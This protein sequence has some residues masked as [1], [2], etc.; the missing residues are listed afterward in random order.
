MPTFLIQLLIGSTVILASVV[1]FSTL[2]LRASA[3][4][5][6]TCFCSVMIALLVLPLLIPFLPVISPIVK[7]MEEPP[8]PMQAPVKIVPVKTVSAE[9]IMLTQ[10]VDAPQWS[11]QPL[12]PDSAT[13]TFVAT[14]EPIIAEPA[15]FVATDIAEPVQNMETVTTPIPWSLLVIVTLLCGMTIRLVML[16]ASIMTTRNLV[17][18]SVPFE[19]PQGLTLAELCRKFRLRRDLEK[20]LTSGQVQVPFAAGTFRPVVFLPVSLRREDTGRLRLVLM[21][22]LAHIARH[23]VFWQLLTRVMLAVYWFHPLAWLLARYIRREREFACDDAVLLLREYPEDYASVLLDISKSLRRK[24]VRLSGCTVAMAQT[25]Q[26]ENRICA[27]LDPERIRKPLGRL[28]AV[29]LVL[30]ACTL[31]ALAGMFS[32]IAREVVSNDEDEV[33]V[34]VEPEEVVQV[35]TP[36]AIKY[37]MV[38]RTEGYPRIWNSDDV[39][40]RIWEADYS[41]IKKIRDP[42]VPFEPRV[43]RLIEID[44]TQIVF[45]IVIIEVNKEVTGKT[46]QEL[47]LEK[48]EN[49]DKTADFNFT[50]P[51]QSIAKSMSSVLDD[52]DK[53]KMATI[54]RCPHIA[55]LDKEISRQEAGGFWAYSGYKDRKYLIEVAPQ[56]MN[57]RIHATI[58]VKHDVDDQRNAKT[59]Q[60][61]TLATL[62]EKVPLF[63]SGLTLKSDD[64]ETDKEIMLCVT[65]VIVPPKTKEPPEPPRSVSFKG[66][67]FMPDGTPAITKDRELMPQQAPVLSLVTEGPKT[68]TVGKEEIY[69]VVVTNKGSVA[70]ETVVI[71]IELPQ[72]A[73]NTQAPE[74]TTGSTSQ[75]PQQQGVEYGIFQWQVGSIKPNKSETLKLHITLHENHPFAL[76]CS[77]DIK[78]QQNNYRYSIPAYPSTL[79]GNLVNAAEDKSLLTSFI[80]GR[81]VDEDGNPLAGIP[82]TGVA[83]MPE[84]LKPGSY[85]GLS[86]QGTTDADG[87]FLFD[88]YETGYVN[89]MPDSPNHASESLAMM[90][91]RGDIGDIVVKEGVRPKVRLLSPDGKPVPSIGV[92]LYRTEPMSLVTS[93]LT[94]ANGECEFRPVLPGRFEIL[95]SKRPHGWHSVDGKEPEE[96]EVPFAFFAKKTDINPQQLYHELR[97][98]KSV[99]VTLRFAEERPRPDYHSFSYVLDSVPNSQGVQ[100]LGF[101]DAKPMGNGVFRFEHVARDIPFDFRLTS[102]FEAYRYALPG[103]TETRPLVNG[104]IVGPFTEDTEIQLVCLQAPTVTLRA[105]DEHGKP[106]LGFY[107]D[108]YYPEINPWRD[109]ETVNGQVVASPRL[110]R[111]LIANDPDRNF[112]GSFFAASD[113]VS[114]WKGGDSGT[115]KISGLQPNENVVL[116]LYDKEQRQGSVS[117]VLKEGEEKEITVTLKPTAENAASNDVPE[118]VPMFNGNAMSPRYGIVTVPPSPASTVPVE[119]DE[120]YIQLSTTIAELN[121]N[122]APQDEALGFVFEGTR[123]VFSASKESAKIILDTLE[124]ENLITVLSRPEIRAL[125]NEMAIIFVGTQEK[126]LYFGI[127]PRIKDGNIHATIE[128]ARNTDAQ[129]I[130]PGTWQK[131]SPLFTNEWT[132]KEGVSTVV[133]GVTVNSDDNADVKKILLCIT[134]RIVMPSR[135]VSFKGKVFMPDG[136]PA[137]FAIVHYGISIPAKN[138]DFPSANIW[139]RIRASSL[140]DEN[141]QYAS[142]GPTPFLGSPATMMCYAEL[143]SENGESLPFVTEPA[144]FDD[145]GERQLKWE[146]DFTLQHAFPVTGKV[147][148]PDGSPA[149]GDEVSFERTFKTDAGETFSDVRKITTDV[150]GRFTLYLPSGEYRYYAKIVN[151]V[152]TQP[153]L[154][155]G[156]VL[157]HDSPIQTVTI[158]ADKPTELEDIVLRNPAMD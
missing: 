43:Y 105:T 104:A 147:R 70:A 61:S 74:L 40:P 85:S 31:T 36:D 38:S 16:T 39:S 150:N 81:L 99:A 149:N 52:L 37:S 51:E 112:E 45:K 129:E 46:I 115:M 64:G 93:A 44:E 118:T 34:A 28:S 151:P 69:K 77:Y 2:L 32:P 111:Q 79:S 59:F 58:T 110:I 62:Q 23:D 26:I 3:A 19:L 18:N 101:D 146:H 145:T 72:W 109:V 98:S 80:T 138:D 15:T 25:H 29:L 30:A 83:Q 122:S 152:D 35:V 71:N 41:D 63:V 130:S 88:L 13:R 121:T 47:I 141:G 154:P 56:I 95:V 92:N 8:Q 140:A 5:R 96:H 82:I 114:F 108:R 131:V 126:G 42:N 4:A 116:L 144:L 17:R 100:S 156:F 84:E 102:S 90:E 136:T 33:V 57:D 125:D 106:I 87:R 142:P 27:I 91:Q 24:P 1:L 97:A 127:V 65:A 148:Y 50:T 48:I 155:N 128:M 7:V 137:S 9:P 21:H 55:T 143:L 75:L 139:H 10:Y 86:L 73:E 133:S 11:T 132:L 67:V 103:D 158:S 12:P 68:S 53:E 78:P 119:T 117:L 76:K 49:R 54:L 153:L 157:F 89:L 107:V 66:E 14:T 124:K 134:P 94:D 120:P 123:L 135:S 22:E 6:H 60:C 20:V 113:A